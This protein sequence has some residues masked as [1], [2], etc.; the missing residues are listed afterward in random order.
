MDNIPASAL[1]RAPM[2]IQDY[3][4]LLRRRKWH[5]LLPI[6]VILLASVLLAFLLPPAF[7]SEATILI[8]REEIPQEF[9]AT[10]VTGY[11]Q[12][13]IQA[14]SQR[15][16]TRKSLYAIVEELDLYP[17]ERTEE[18]R[19]DIV[20]QM[21]QS[22]GVEMVD[23]NAS[24]AGSSRQMVATVAFT[25][26][27][28][29][30]DAEL[31]AV[32]C[33]R[34]AALFLEKNREDRAEL[35]AGVSSFLTS[36]AERLEGE[37]LGYEQELARFKQEHVT[38]MPELNSV[39]MTLFERTEA[40]LE[41]SEEALRSL[42][43]RTLR[44]QGEL[45][46]T[47]RYKPLFTG[48]K[49]R[50]LSPNERLAVLLSE[51]MEKS[52]LYSSEHPDIVR[53][54]RE[55]ASLEQSGY[56]QGAATAL[57]DAL[58]IRQAELGE[59]LRRYSEEHPD[60][61][62]LRGEIASLTQ[63][64]DTARNTAIAGGTAEDRP[65]DNPPYVALRVQLDALLVGIRAENA[66]R[67]QLRL[68]LREYEER[69]FKTPAVEREYLAL[70]R[71]YQSA[72]EKYQELKEKQRQARLAEELERSEKAERFTVVQRASPSTQPVAPNRPAIVLLG[73]VLA[74]GAGLVS[75]SVSEF[76]DSTVR[77]SRGV[78]RVVLAPPLAVIPYIATDAD[79]R[80]SRVKRL[81]LLVLVGAVV[82]VLLVFGY[83]AYQQGEAIAPPAPVANG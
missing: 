24:N 26:S 5:L 16:L 39:N 72:R 77:G 54:K 83:E 50:V 27:F 73:F 13:R 28:D 40:A 4:A 47:D 59:L 46:I 2:E 61:K 60:V 48:G 74:S 70:S 62:R 42:E 76:L 57:K 36:E 65:A 21:R 82:L 79:R 44:L 9:V 3:L 19:L 68:K 63:Q 25:V 37:I 15:I 30:T 34:L 17:D 67:D 80:R 23:I 7:R 12:E 53:L 14:I 56:G 78:I 64:L 51:L 32:V 52:T 29:Y 38:H 81:L 31:A 41:R 66:N 71:D 35:A 58:A 8:E 11:V 69:L 49:E 43:E 22:I 18:N 55:I 20:R 75:V 33:N 45:A 1:E 10:T 6:G